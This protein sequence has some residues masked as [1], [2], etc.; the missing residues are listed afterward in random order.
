MVLQMGCEPY[1]RPLINQCSVSDLL[2]RDPNELPPFYRTGL[3][4]VDN[5]GCFLTTFFNDAKSSDLN[6]FIL[7]SVASS[8]MAFFI[9][10]AIESTRTTSRLFARWYLAVAVIAQGFGMCVASTLLWLPSLMMG[11]SGKNKHGALRSGIVWTIAILQLIPTIAVLI[12]IEGPSNIDTLAFTVFVFTYAPIVMPLV[13]IPVGL[14]LYIIYGPVHTIPNAMRTGSRVAHVLY[15]VLSVAS[16]VYWLYSL[17]ALVFPLNILPSAI[18]P[19]TLSQFTSLLQSSWSIESISAAFMS[20]EQVQSTELMSIFDDIV[21]TAIHPTGK[22][23][24]GF[25][26]GVDLLVVWLAMILWSGVEDGICT[27]LRMV[28]GG[29]VFGPGA[30]IFSYAARRETRLGGLNHSAYAKSKIE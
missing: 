9:I 5:I 3:P 7:R 15:E 27:S 24:V 13:W 28:V 10:A 19:T 20:I 22:E 26:L 12:M 25:F 23:L 14:L 6:I 29:I 11:Y 17:W 18:L 2:Q 30:S 21:R 16:A 1:N 8:A 4:V